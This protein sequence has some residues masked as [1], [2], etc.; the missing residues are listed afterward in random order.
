VERLNLQLFKC[1]VVVEMGDHL[2][3]IDMGRKLGA[4]PLLGEA[5]SISRKSYVACR[6]TPIAMNLSP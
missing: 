2:A 6:V 1:S 5:G 4:V 3:T